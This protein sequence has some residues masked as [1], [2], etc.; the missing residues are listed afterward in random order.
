[1]LI[2]IVITGANGAVGTALIQFLRGRTSAPP[3]RVRALVRSA[4]RAGSLGA[5]R[6]KV[7][8]TDYSSP[9]S[10]R[11][12]VAGA[13]A[14]VHL[15]GALMPRRGETLIEANIQATRS[16]VYAARGAGVRSLIYLSYP[17]AD[18]GSDNEYLR[19]KGVAEGII[20]GA[21][22]AGAIFR[23][24][25]ILGPRSPSF[26]ALAK[27]AAA[28]LVPLVGGGSVRIQP[29]AETD[30]LGA[31]DWALSAAP[32]PIPVFN[33]VGE[34]TLSYAEL[35]RKVGRRLGKKPRILP[36]PRSVARWSAAVAG[37]CFPSLGWN[38]SLFGILF[39]EHLVES[40]AVTQ[41]LGMTL[42]PLDAALARALN[43]AD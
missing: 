14:V 37:A 12:A 24:P 35:V 11:A 43:S 4:K 23:V 27:M 42:T 40:A 41:A 19:T 36:V 8:E 15:A 17:D 16:V 2:E 39:E 18:P 10:L 21:G 38:L 32:Q 20:R 34:E 28:P 1:M 7:V 22:F 29:I 31:I 30:V 5:L 6:V 13:Q 9:D 26:K 33:L 3:A 25:M